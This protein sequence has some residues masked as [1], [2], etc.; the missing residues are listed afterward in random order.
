MA[1]F[2]KP[3]KGSG[4][5]ARRA[6]KK[7]LDK[8]RVFVNKVVLERD[9]YKCQREGCGAPAVHAHHVY[10]RGNSRE[11]EFEQPKSRLSLCE[12]HHREH[13]HIGGITR[14]DLIKDLERALT[15]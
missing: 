9:S 15:K 13:H 8:F 7:K 5:A 6:R 4:T 3:K 2:P 14:A 10:G 12:K 1:L 11:H